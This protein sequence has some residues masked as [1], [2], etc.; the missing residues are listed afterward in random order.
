[1]EGQATQ[2]QFA[3][4]IDNLF[5]KHDVNSDGHLDRTEAHEALVDAH[6][7]FGKGNPFNEDKFDEAF[8]AM[9]TDKDG[10]ISKEELF[11]FL[12][13]IATENG[14]LSN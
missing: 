11:N 13:K 8:Q 10:Q 9:D 2:E 7:R 3:V 4:M 1:M 12:H 5:A 6:Q 14:K